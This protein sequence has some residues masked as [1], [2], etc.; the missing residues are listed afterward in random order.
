M[1][2]SWAISEAK[3]KKRVEEDKVRREALGMRIPKTK[4]KIELLRR[5]KEE[6]VQNAKTLSKLRSN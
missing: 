1:S 3:M 6:L 5:R 4:N 2:E